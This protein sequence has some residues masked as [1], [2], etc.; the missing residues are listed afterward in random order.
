M[1]TENST[2]TE[3]NVGTTTHGNEGSSLMLS[4]AGRRLAEISAPSS[5]FEVA[6]KT[7]TAP[8]PSNPLQDSLAQIFKRSPR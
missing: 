1:K 4:E 8:G 5:A 7:K 3:F 6:E 2:G